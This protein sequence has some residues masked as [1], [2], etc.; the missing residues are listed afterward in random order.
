MWY[1]PMM[2]RILG[3]LKQVVGRK[4]PYIL[5]MQGSSWKFPETYVQ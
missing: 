1:R 3:N 2:V 4:L 5:P